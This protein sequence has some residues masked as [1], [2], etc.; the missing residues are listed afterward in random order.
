[1]KKVSKKIISL[2]LSAVMVV[3]MLP[4][5]ALTA[6]AKTE[7]E[8][9]ATTDFT[10][11]YWT[12]KG[13]SGSYNWAEGSG[14]TAIS[15]SGTSDYM[16][17]DSLQYG[18]NSYAKGM[19]YSGDPAWQVQAD[20]RGACMSDSYLYLSGYY[21]NGVAQA[22]TPITGLSAFKVEFQF[23]YLG[24]RDRNNDDVFFKISDYNS[25]NSVYLTS[26]YNDKK[27]MGDDGSTSHVWFNQALNGTMRS[28]S[29]GSYQ[30][31][32]I[33]SN[34]RLDHKSGSSNFTTNTYYKYVMSYAHDTVTSY[35]EDLNGNVIVNLGSVTD[36]S[37]RADTSNIACIN[38]GAKDGNYL[39]NIAVKYAWVYKGTEN[40]STYSV[41]AEKD[42]YLFSYFTGNDTEDLHLAVSDDGYNFEGLNANR[43][44]WD[45]GDLPASPDVYPKKDWNNNDV[46]SI[47]GDFSITGHVR[48]PYI[49]QAEDGTY[50]CLATDLQ[51]SR[52]WSNNNC[53][54]VWHVDDPIN[55][56]E[57]DPWFVD[58]Q[59]LAANI[60]GRVNRAWAP[61][62]IWDPFENAYMVHFAIQT[63]TLGTT[64]LYYTYTTDFK[65]FTEPKRLLQVSYYNIDSNINYDGQRYV[66]T[67]KYE[68]ENRVYRCT[69]E[70]PN[71]PYSNP[72]KL[73]TSYNAEGCEVY[74][75]GTG[76][77]LTY[78]MILDDYSDSGHFRGFTANSMTGL[79][80][81]SE[82]T[83][84]KINHLSPR[85]G[86]VVR[87]TTAQY[88]SLIEKY[89]KQ[90]YDA[91]VK[92]VGYEVN[93][94][95]IARYFTDSDLTYN[96]ATGEENE[97]SNHGVAYT[98]V[99]GKASA[100]FSGGSKTASSAYNTA[101]GQY[102]YAELSTVGSG[103]K[104]FST[105]DIDEGI[106]FDWYSKQSESTTA[107]G[108]RIFE[109]SDCTPGTLAWSGDGGHN[110]S[111]N[112]EASAYHSFSASNKGKTT[113]VGYFYSTST[114]GYPKATSTEWQHYTLA[115][116]NDQIY[117][118]VDG[119]LISQC[120]AR[121][122][123]FSSSW[124]S[125]LK[126]GGHLMFGLSSYAG[127]FGFNGYI[128][129]FRI[130]KGTYTP[131]EIELSIK[132]LENTE[133]AFNAND[134]YD[135]MENVTVDGVEYKNYTNSTT[136][137]ETDA[138]GTVLS[139]NGANQKATLNNGDNHNYTGTASNTGYSVAFW[140]NAGND[141]STAE[142]KC[143][144]NIGTD[145]DAHYFSFHESGVLFYNFE[146]S[147][148][149]IYNAFGTDSVFSENSATREK[150]KNQWHHYIIRIIPNGDF[151]TIYFF[152]DGNLVNTVNTSSGYSVTA[153]KAVHDYFAESRD[154]TFGRKP[155][156]WENASRGYLDDFRIYIGNH[157]SVAEVYTRDFYGA[158]VI[159]YAMKVYEDKMATVSSS[160]I[161][162]NMLPAYNAYVKCNRVKDA[163]EY[164]DNRRAAIAQAKPAID[165]LIS[166]TEAM[167]AWSAY[168]GS[169]MNAYL[170]S[171]EPATGAFSNILYSTS[172]YTM[173]NSHNGT[174]TWSSGGAWNKD[175]SFKVFAPTKVLMYY[176][177][178]YDEEKGIATNCCFP[179]G[180]E[181][182]RYRKGSNK[183]IQYAYLVKTGV[184]PSD[185]GTSGQP[186]GTNGDPDSDLTL[187]R[188]WNGYQDDW[189]SGDSMPWSNLGNNA[190]HFGYYRYDNTNGTQYPPDGGD[191]SNGH[192]VYY[193]NAV[194][195]T[196]KSNLN[197]KTPLI[198]QT[199]NSDG[200]TSRY[201][202]TASTI[203]VVDYNKLKTGLADNATKVKTVS[204]YKLGGMQNLIKLFDKATSF[205]LA[206]YRSGA[207]AGGYYLDGTETDVTESN[208]GS[209]YS[210]AQDACTWFN[211]QLSSATATADTNE[212]NQLKAK[213]DE[214]KATY[215]RGFDNLNKEFTLTSTANFLYAYD[216]AAAH[217]QGLIE[218]DYAKATATTLKSALNVKHNNLEP[219]ANLT[220][221]EKA[222]EKA[223]SWLLDQNGKVAQY[224][225]ASVQALIN[226]MNGIGEDSKMSVYSMVTADAR[227]RLDLGQWTVG[228]DSE[229]LATAINTAYANLKIAT[230][231]ATVDTSAYE[232]AVETINHLDP[233]AY[234][235]TDSITSA[236]STVNSMMVGGTKNYTMG[237]DSS[238]INVV[239][240][241]VTTQTV[242]DATSRI[243]T[244][245][246]N[247]VK[248]YDI[249][250][251]GGVTDISSNIGYYSTTD[252]N[253]TYG[254]K[255]TFR[256]ADN[257]TAWYLD[258]NSGTVHKKN[259]FY[260]YGDKLEVKTIGDLTVTAVRRTGTQKRV[261]ILRNYYDNGV[262]LEGQPI[263]FANFVDN[264]T[265][266]TLPAAPA[267]AY[268]DFNGYYIK[269]VKYNAGA[270]VTI[271]AD[272]DII[273][274]YDA[275]DASC[276]ITATDINGNSIPTSSVK[277]NEKVELDGGEGTYGWIEQVGTTY[278]PFYYGRKLEMNASEST[279][280][281]AVNETNF[282]KYGT[283]PCVN[284]RQGGV[285]LSGT[286]TTFNAQLVAIDMDAVQEYGILIGAPSTKGGYEAITPT[287]SQITVENSGQQQ[288]YAVLR[289]KSTKL[290]GANQFAI[291]VNNLPE[292]YKYRGYVIY[293]DG[294]SLQ[295]VYT[296]VM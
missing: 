193:S 85:H 237:V 89:G 78:A 64:A 34:K 170:Q 140:Y 187:I 171:T 126:S 65:T 42:K 16:T 3:S 165:D 76:T 33:S 69:S 155:I 185:S 14:F 260:G 265:E 86:S 252:H 215:D 186:T 110:I 108:H 105:T 213:M 224:D 160:N 83:A 123:V 150:Y 207:T 56:D 26:S 212:Y 208:V 1:M 55:I 221:I 2:L 201:N 118:F 36:A 87:I 136:V 273:A 82:N 209:Y 219:L 100:Y 109:V 225:A 296:D 113:G 192:S 116:S 128:H 248:K 21:K 161:Y 53:L 9:L 275:S 200:N 153:G 112:L 175:F 66:M 4:A 227:T 274:R 167:T 61:E 230:T 159:D 63:T 280:L 249:V 92:L 101:D 177:G 172:Y 245:L 145:N 43:A 23:C 117:Y 10:K 154:V 49:F 234:D 41:P 211:S 173:G 288:G 135:P 17:W 178:V 79:S 247:S 90:T 163:I 256:S 132:D 80:T 111:S 146:G 196:G 15:G 67:F 262:K 107:D 39:Q 180:F 191:R 269:G 96:A 197:A 204:N 91:D 268:Y 220:N 71:G 244:A 195:Y 94:A 179:I 277:Y 37:L 217:M 233:D 47:N 295:T 141:V 276:A 19:G 8:L 270:T 144:F 149:D 198:L 216:D 124:L 282:K 32:A 184:G 28:K 174:M 292:G 151:D 22:N 103:E 283:I 139:L 138:H 70:R 164:G 12:K 226:A 131:T 6:S 62:A 122:A 27:N 285:V 102:L 267:Y 120:P 239:N 286:K 240:N 258:V 189:P 284:L 74:P 104:S 162:K 40:D 137:S 54:M 52:G 222:Y 158:D 93:D 77:D 13:S 59:R 176:D 84:F 271:S 81:D 58:V 121:T 202:S 51:C 152:I 98:E 97:L 5:F 73:N 203:Y 246:T 293:T 68:G 238:T 166:K 106:T 279:T 95:L 272:T 114:L 29:D 231:D 188:P 88:N 251:S 266:Y 243:L 290:V 143:I 289:A 72:V 133:S 46:T 57:T 253:A 147:F 115:V 263:Q 60:G 50:Y 250:T 168:T 38:I 127:D 35:I 20:S 190:N 31:R 44:I 142:R 30:D 291:S 257:D 254:T 255:M 259:A 125:A 223:N 229:D 199:Y 169:K 218:N 183:R 157:C 232:A 181:M 206:K 205:D 11:G 241:S 242:G 210:Y 194:Y 148:A 264:G 48:D 130:Y 25:N 287:Q 236:I 99:D 261:R 45:S 294:S 281:V 228:A 129:D 18:E 235:T 24:N 7:W 182:W 75:I 278:R 214:V 134:F 119:V 156:Y